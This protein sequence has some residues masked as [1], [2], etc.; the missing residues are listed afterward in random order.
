M[1][2][3]AI[4]IAG[5]AMWMLYWALK[6]GLAFGPIAAE[7]FMNLIR[8]HLGTTVTV[9]FVIILIFGTLGW[10]YPRLKR[11]IPELEITKDIETILNMVLGLAN[12]NISLTENEEVPVEGTDLWEQLF[13]GGDSQQAPQQGQ[14][15]PSSQQQ[16]QSQQAPQQ[17]QQVPSSQQQQVAECPLIEDKVVLA[18]CWRGQ[19]LPHLQTATSGG[20]QWFPSGMPITMEWHLG[21]AWTPDDFWI[22]ALDLG[23]QKFKV[24]KAFGGTLAA[25][26]GQSGGTLY[27]TGQWPDACRVCPTVETPAEAEL[28][29]TEG[30]ETTQAWITLELFPINTT[31]KFDTCEGV[32]LRVTG[33]TLPNFPVELYR[34]GVLVLDLITANNQGVWSAVIDNDF[35]IWHVE[36]PGGR[37]KDWDHH[38]TCPSL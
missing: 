27:G 19:V 7:K 9:V 13:G 30:N 29:D 2:I 1:G 15:V 26:A 32:S 11:K 14:Q 12:K 31:G 8:A 20:L 34:D 3:G 17:G 35:G 5:I 37:S 36:V 21:T 22:T 33:A 16:Q 4:V 6:Y 23:L 38:L 24:L 28:T 10:G 18:D 25:L